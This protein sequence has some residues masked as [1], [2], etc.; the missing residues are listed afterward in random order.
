VQEEFGSGYSLT[1]LKVIRKLY[2]TYP[3]FLSPTEKG[4]PL[5]DQL[6]ESARAVEHSLDWRPGQFSPNISWR[7][8]IASLLYERL[9]TRGLE[10][11]KSNVD[12]A[13]RV[14]MS[15]GSNAQDLSVA[16]I[17]APP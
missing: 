16:N 14:G 2:V 7:H 9:A 15:F 4:Q 13:I 5:A 3:R 11:T 6:V 12:K 1:N 10:Q 17:R 8:Y